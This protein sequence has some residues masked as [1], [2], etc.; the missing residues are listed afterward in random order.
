MTIKI[1]NIRCAGHR[2]T[3]SPHLFDLGKYLY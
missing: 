1:V 3:G 2:N